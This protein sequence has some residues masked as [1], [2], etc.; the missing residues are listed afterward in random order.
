MLLFRKITKNK[1]LPAKKATAEL[2][3]KWKASKRRLAT[4]LQR[5]SELMSAPVKKFCLI[6][7]C[8]LFGGSSIAIIIHSATSKEQA[9]RVT[10]ITKPAHPERNDLTSLAPDSV[11][12]KREYERVIGFKN[13]LLQLKSDSI[14]KQQY[15]S[16]MFIRPK[17]MDSINLFE[18]MYLS[19][20]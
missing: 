15:D 19:Q 12:T 7:F 5:K 2:M 9:V 17:L 11:I 8:V 3:N 14:R 13:Y 18:K 6:F 20:K 10:T 16:I 4:Y 1:K